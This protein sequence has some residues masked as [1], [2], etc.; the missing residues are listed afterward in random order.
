[1]VKQQYL[2]NFQV[3]K[4]INQLIYLFILPNIN[5][6]LHLYSPFLSNLDER[7]DQQIFLHVPIIQ[8]HSIYLFLFLVCILFQNYNQDSEVQLTINKFSSTFK[9]LNQ[10]ISVKFSPFK[11]GHGPM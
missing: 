6:L 8:Q 3:F 4:N 9:T 2:K 11:N 1:M 5:Q 10:P 7:F